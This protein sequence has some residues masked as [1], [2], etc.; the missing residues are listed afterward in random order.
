VSSQWWGRS[1]AAGEAVSDCQESQ[2][3]R[4]LGILISKMAIHER[5]DGE[6]ARR[7]S[8]PRD[9]DA[10]AGTFSVQEGLMIRT[11]FMI[12][13]RLLGRVA[14]IRNAASIDRPAKD[15]TR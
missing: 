5:P 2:V 13:L 8:H 4:L 10:T 7:R 14:V 11:K 1:L 12:A 15:S 3:S 6:S 9:G